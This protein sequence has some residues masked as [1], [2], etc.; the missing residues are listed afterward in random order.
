MR[1]EA[2]EKCREVLPLQV[3]HDHVRRARL[4]LADI[5]DR[6]IV[7]AAKPRGRA[8]LAEKAAD[9]RVV[10]EG[11]GGHELQRDRGVEVNVAR[12]DDDPHPAGA[13]H[14]L[15]PVLSGE[16]LPH[17]RRRNAIGNADVDA[18]L[19]PKVEAIRQGAR[20]RRRLQQVR[21]VAQRPVSVDRA[22]IRR[23]PSWATICGYWQMTGDG[24][25]TAVM[26]P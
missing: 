22:P 4:E 18:R 24:E 8:R 25:A 15:D 16:H 21:V 23:F 5:R 6:R 7:L 19:V 14:P 3:L 20:S 11:L 1:P 26:R 12:G 9:E 17:P 10:R 2:R 13:E